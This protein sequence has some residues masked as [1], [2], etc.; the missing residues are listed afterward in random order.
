M[1]SQ[2]TP[3]LDTRGLFSRVHSERLRDGSE[4]LAGITLIQIGAVLL[5]EKAALR[6]AAAHARSPDPP[7]LRVD[8][9]DAATTRPRPRVPH[10]GLECCR[11]RCGDRCRTRRR[12]GRAGRLRT[13]LSD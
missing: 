7:T 6:P 1:I 11:D 13:G 4:R 10:A 2:P 9:T 8:E 5:L 12:L 3:R